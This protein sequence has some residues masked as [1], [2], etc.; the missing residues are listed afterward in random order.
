MKWTQSLQKRLALVFAVIIV[1]VMLIVLLL[2]NRA[3]H[4]IRA[5]TYEKMS[6]QADYYQDI[7]ETEVENGLTQQLEFFNNRRLVFLGVPNSGLSAYEER[8]A[9]LDVRERI[10]II[11][12]SNNLIQSGILYIPKTNRYIDSGS[13][14]RM[15]QKDMEDMERYLRANENDLYFDGESFYSV[16]TGETGG[17]VADSPT[18]VFVI[19]F[20]SKQIEDNLSLFNASTEGGSFL[21]DEEYDAM[22][23]RDSSEVTER[24]IWER[25]TRNEEG[26]YE[27]VQNV[28]IGGKRYLVLVGGKGHLGRFVQYIDESSLMESVN[29]LWVWTL[30][31]LLLMGIMAVVFILYTRRMVHR[32]L[33]KLVEAF[34]R[35]KKGDLTE[36]LY[37]NSQD[38][39]AYLYRAFNDMEDQL[40]N[41]I[42]EVYVQ[43]NLA[44]KAQL[45]Q[46]QAQINPH[47][48]YNSFF[49]LRRRIKRGDYDGA[50]EIASHLG[51]YFKYVTRDG[52][53]FLQLNQELAH[54]K[55]Y[56]AIQQARFAGRMRVEFGE[57]PESLEHVTVPRLIIQPLLE[58]AFA[59]GL[60][61]RVSN[62]I[63]RV[64]I[65]WDKN[66]I[67]IRVEDNGEETTDDVIASMQA[68]LNDPNPKEVTGLIN[69]H[70]RLKVY[71]KGEGGLS[72]GR[73]ELGGAAITIQ[74]PITGGQIMG[75]LKLREDGKIQ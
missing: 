17:I 37:L 40:S 41:L 60:E 30:M 3:V 69:I 72:V 43:K 42:D 57:L 71:F 45:K 66:E 49:I 32:P 47:F 75:E 4:I 59:H 5:E 25:L 27:S 48:L 29:G 22:L 50:E 24:E 34:E 21:Y 67:R 38:E 58:N 2:H 54:A 15:T 26:E 13:A 55:S 23:G 9:V 10:W 20:S 53:D 36:H 56:A 61:N 16:C 65:E 62:A 28:R 44:Q 64:A 35:L 12:Q 51:D 68:A 19:T 52:S 73:S 46:L 39:F 31:L 11:T 7:L 6:V 63:L 18:F 14:H 70:R 1:S 8:E 33:T 74:I